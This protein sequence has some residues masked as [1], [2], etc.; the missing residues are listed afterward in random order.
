MRT[1]RPCPFHAHTCSDRADS[2]TLGP[3]GDGPALAV[4]AG[5][6]CPCPRNASLTRRQWCPKYPSRPF[7]PS[8]PGAASQQVP[9]DVHVNTFPGTGTWTLICPQKSSYCQAFSSKEDSRRTSVEGRFRDRR[10]PRKHRAQGR[11]GPGR[12]CRGV[13]GPSEGPSGQEGWDRGHVS[14]L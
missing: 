11:M 9:P 3:H 13:R 6:A 7:T 14:I 2:A 4:Q 1:P 12:C 10:G 5:T 8:Q